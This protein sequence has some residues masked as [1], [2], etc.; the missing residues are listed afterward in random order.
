MVRSASYQYQ[1]KQ[2][3]DVV[4]VPLK[5]HFLVPYQRNLI[6]TPRDELSEQLNQLLAQKRKDEQI[7]IALHGLGGSG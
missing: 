2:Y 1:E 3:F 5:K 6:F 7:R 4:S